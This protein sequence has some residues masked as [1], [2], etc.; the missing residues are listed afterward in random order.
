LAKPKSRAFPQVPVIEATIEHF[1]IVLFAIKAQMVLAG[2]AIALARTV[3]GGDGDFPSKIFPHQSDNKKQVRCR[4]RIIHAFAAHWL[5]GVWLVLLA[6]EVFAQSNNTPATKWFA[7][8]QRETNSAKKIAALTKAVAFDSLFFEAHHQLAQL[9]AGQENLARA[10]FHF[11]RAGMLAVTSPQNQRAQILFQL[12]AVRLKLGKILEAETALREAQT[13]APARPLQAAI[14][15]E[16]G[17]LLYRQRRY[18]EALTEFLKQVE[19]DTA[20]NLP[21]PKPADGFAALYLQAQRHGA[22]GAAEKALVI[23]DSLLQQVGALAVTAR[24]A[25][26]QADS[27][28]VW[29]L[30]AALAPREQKPNLLYPIGVAAT[31]VLVPLLG[32]MFFS[33]TARANFYLWR[34]NYPAAARIFENMLKRHPKKTNLYAPLAELYLRLGR[35]DERALKVYQTVLQ[36]NL[37]TRRRDELN[38]ALAQKYLA[39]GRTD[40]DAIEVLEMALKVESRKQSRSLKALK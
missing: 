21:A 37:P 7:R 9:Y 13:L 40:S 6:P 19:L 11:D 12:A 16:L 3:F 4:M 30:S 23:Y 18:P 36:L 32:L 17:T 29:P 14:L 28:R 10:E 26:I 20:A 8:S 1:L 24:L 2:E 39:E 34:K 27:H 38:A 31:I 25:G 15:L 35:N 5:L 33:P 22:A